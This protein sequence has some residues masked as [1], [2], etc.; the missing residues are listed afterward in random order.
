VIENVNENYSDERIA[1]EDPGRFRL[2]KVCHGK[3]VTAN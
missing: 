3:K 1:D 2:H